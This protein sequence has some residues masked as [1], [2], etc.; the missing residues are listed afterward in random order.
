[1]DAVR[2][3]IVLALLVV[4]GGA[5]AGLAQE[6]ELLPEE[7]QAEIDP[8]A[9]NRAYV[10]GVLGRDEVR[11]AARVAGVDV[12]RALEGVDALEGARL[13]RATRQAQLL[14]RHMGESQDRISLTATTL[15][16]IL[17]LV[18]VIILVA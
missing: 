4:A 14:D 16:I 17:L 11:T 10:K 6:A 1:M 8:A 9:A 7:P 13:D 12:D 3:G 5:T 18:L 15:I 2:R